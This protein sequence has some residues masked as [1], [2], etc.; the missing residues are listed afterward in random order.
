MT[1]QTVFDDM[2]DDL[3]FLAPAAPVDMA[4]ASQQK[5]VT[6]PN[7][8]AYRDQCKR[9]H[10]SGKFYSY[11]GRLVG[12]CFYCKGKGYQEF[13]TS[14]ADREKARAAAAHRKQAERKAWADDHADV[15]AW[16][17]HGEDRCN[18]FALSL[19]KAL[20]DHGSLT[21]GQVNA[22]RK[23]IARDAERAAEKAKVV[24]QAPAIATEALFESF[25]K[26]EASGLKRPKLRFDGFVIS[27]A[28]M[29]GRNAGALYVVSEDDVYLGKIFQG[30][31]IT[32]RDCTDAVRDQVIEL[33]KDPAAAA[34]AY[35]L[36]TGSC[37][38]CGREL[39][40]PVS[41]AQGIGPICAGR[42]GF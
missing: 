5:F 24:E 42:F 27:K 13:K 16:I 11:T 40:D 28:P 41:V 29:S 18:E 23:C 33:I 36:R 8:M 7:A 3:D 12:S 21:E 4:T 15:V 10:G 34:K 17:R 35:G 14:A 31:F 20:A 9:C 38:I 19:G 22:V 25:G 26:A 1:F 32:S 30:K 37:C 2:A 39:T 6:A